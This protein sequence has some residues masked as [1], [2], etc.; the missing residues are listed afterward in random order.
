M[1]ADGSYRAIRRA[2]DAGIP[3]ICYNTCL[4]DADQK[5]FISAYA[6]G[7]PFEFGNKL[8][9]AAAEYFTAQG[10]LSPGSRC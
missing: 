5:E 6:V 2:H 1:S 3:V 10:S 8:G 7:D 9:M 4:S